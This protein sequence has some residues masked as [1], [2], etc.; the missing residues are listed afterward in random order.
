MRE[1]RGRWPI[2]APEELATRTFSP[3]GA[4]RMRCFFNRRFARLR[5][6]LEQGNLSPCA[7]GMVLRAIPR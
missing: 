5:P 6:E 1:Q 3:L 7:F 4:N 2:N